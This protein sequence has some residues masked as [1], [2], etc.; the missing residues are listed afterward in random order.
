MRLVSGTGATAARRRRTVL[1]LFACLAGGLASA[2]TAPAASAAGGTIAGTVTDSD[3]APF[4]GG[5]QVSIYRDTGSGGWAH[6]QGAYVVGDKFSFSVPAGM[7]RACVTPTDDSLGSECWADAHEL[8]LSPPASA[9]D[10]PVIEDATVA[11]DVALD[12][13]ARIAGTVT[14]SA[15]GALAGI[16]VWA[17]GFDRDAG[18][19]TN[20]RGNALTDQTGSYLI[21]GLHPGAYRVCAEPHDGIHRQECW[22]EAATVD[23][24][25][26]VNAPEGAVAEGID[27]TLS[28][29]ATIS[30][31]VL[32]AADQPTYAQAAAL[33]LDP[34]TGQWKVVKSSYTDVTW[35]G[36]RTGTYAIRGLEPGTYRVCFS[37]YELIDECWDDA[38]KVGQARDIVVGFEQTV[39]GVTASLDPGGAIEGTV[40]GAYLGAQGEVAAD[41]YRLVAGNWELVDAQLERESTNEASPYRIV[42]LATGTY[43]VCLRHEDPEFVP[44]F[45]P[46]CYGGTP[47]VLSGGDIPVTAP[48]TTTGIDIDLDAPSRISGRVFGAAEPVAVDL[49]TASGR[50]IAGAMT[51][52]DGRYGWPDLPAGSYKLAF[53]RAPAYTPLAAEFYQ[54]V[55]ER[56]GLTGATVVSLTEATAATGVNGTLDAGGSITGHVVDGTGDGV[57]GCR[58]EAYTD[59]ASLVTRRAE[60]A[61]DGAFD[62][63]GLSTGAYKLRILGSSC[64]LAAEHVYYDTQSRSALVAEPARADEIAVTLGTAT[65]LPRVLGEVV[66]IEL[67]HSPARVRGRTITTRVQVPSGS[68][69]VTLVAKRHG[70]RRRGRPTLLEAGAPANTLR[71]RVPR[72]GSWRV[73]LITDGKRIGLGTVRVG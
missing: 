36:A 39:T 40:S 13:A 24:A 52:P 28:P 73:S 10:I 31:K 11:I 61:V 14:E 66:P 47:T 37:S 21:T 17:Y 25:N 12:D 57:A 59:D 69:T 71:V 29:G 44:G 56:N 19:W 35:D 18:A 2:L 38:E 55:P 16:E 58:L 22:Q 8:L 51:A 23:G 49:Y 27:M 45:A 33:A 4:D 34:V 3:G 15:G 70:V 64:A 42:G 5:Y 50:L 68:A 41:V 48:Q 60:S 72:S 6:F 30:G 53:N 9:T 67:N 32:D 46:E 1:A 43:R 62:I 54:H 63:G 26:D 65:A 20:T 7:F